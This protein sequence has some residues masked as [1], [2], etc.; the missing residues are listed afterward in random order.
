LIYHDRY[1]TGANMNSRPGIRINMLGTPVVELGGAAV[2]LP[3][4][5]T[6]ALLFFLAGSP[7]SHSRDELVDLLWPDLD[8]ARG[9]RQLTDALSDI[10]RAL[11]DENV[12]RS[13][14]ETVS[15]A[16]PASDVTELSTLVDEATLRSG[17]KLQAKLNAA[18]N[19]YRGEFLSGV[20]ISDA[21][22]FEDWLQDMRLRTSVIAL[23]SFARLAFVA[24]ESGDHA[25]AIRVAQRGLQFDELREDLWR[26]LIEAR[27]RLGDRSGAM[28]DYARCRDVLKRELGANPEEETETLR[29][30]ILAEAGSSGTGSRETAARAARPPLPP[31]NRLPQGAL[32]LVGR[33]GE[34][35]AL[36]NAWKSAQDKSGWITVVGEP[37]I[38]KTRLISEFLNRA[39]ANGAVVFSARCPDLSDPSPYGPV[40]DAVRG[41]LPTV[42][43]N[44]LAGLDAVWL[45]WLGT[46]IPELGLG[47]EPPESTGFEEDRSHMAEAVG[48]ALAAI[49]GDRASILFLDDLHWAHPAT[50]VMLRAIAR[51]GR[52]ILVAGTLRD[53]EPQ[54]AGSKAVVDVIRDLHR[55]G[56]AREIQLGP[57][58]PA[59]TQ[60][61]VK[62]AVEA[63]N[64][65]V[66]LNAVAVGRLSEGLPLF[67]IEL[68]RAVIESPDN[69]DLPESLR[70]AIAVRIDR[71][72]PMARRALEIAAVFEAE[73]T[74]QLLGRA[75]GID[76]AGDDIVSAIEELIQRRLLR[77][78]AHGSITFAHGLI[79]TGVYRSLS[80]S[81]RR[82]LHKR[83][84][85]AL[86]MSGDIPSGARHDAIAR[87]FRLSGE[88]VLAAE[89]LMAA[90]ERADA[91]GEVDFAYERF[92]AAAELYR[93]GGR[94]RNSAEALERACVSTLR[95]CALRM[96][97]YRTALT[98]WEGVPD[99][100]EARTR[101]L[102]RLALVASQNPADLESD[103][104]ELLVET[105]LELTKG[106][107]GPD[108][109]LALA[110][111]ANVALLRG[112]S[113]EQARE[114]ASEAIA[115]AGDSEFAWQNAMDAMAMV[116]DE[117]GRLDRSIEV[118]EVAGERAARHRNLYHM[119]TV[120]NEIGIRLLKLGR[121]AVAEERFRSAESAARQAGL[122]SEIVRSQSFLGLALVLQEKWDEALEILAPLFDGPRLA[123]VG[124]RI[125]AMQGYL[126]AESIA[127]RGNS[128]SG[129]SIL[130]R[131]PT[132]ERIEQFIFGMLKEARDRA[133][134]A[135][136][137]SS[138]RQ[139]IGSP[140][141][142]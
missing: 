63:A 21:E 121:F 88:L 29:R 123:G 62:L 64:S 104:L 79:R 14:S 110:A 115:I 117:S 19:L 72:T 44:V 86:E 34:L 69:P 3:R 109:S 100:I 31:A 113:I 5:R 65:S 140:G 22:P 11:E 84:A 16:G 8:P 133:Y 27:A 98:A 56:I 126:L 71:T 139:A 118:L 4:R 101:L 75:L 96:A 120:H 17:S 107:N 35:G 46:I 12:I 53:T 10:K 54:T 28:A 51:S 82:A 83:A 80:S 102:S 94:D 15:W 125:T 1:P 99:N 131:C 142:R 55:D 61:L 136:E 70:N 93:R 132:I 130:S 58:S 95:A 39:V 103:E 92:T 111:A 106:A 59:E 18:V 49:A 57:L 6:R 41:A 119:S 97:D 26:A 36:L 141:Q 60:A 89:H 91:T 73:T 138:L 38:G 9:R 87:H 134:A 25:V 135:V 112:D 47:V 45:R 48:R 122:Q 2:R 68:T 23:G 116:L 128:E 42:E 74:V 77:E 114:M 124:L 50:V 129:R 40:E 90:G 76:P 7:G 105:A 127:R 32:T 78:D 85:S 108:R 67:T 20:T 81:R 52:N 13:D 43:A 24:M 37:G 66:R 137:G 30:Q 33:A